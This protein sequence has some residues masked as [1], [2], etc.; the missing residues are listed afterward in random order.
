MVSTII[1]NLIS[2]AIKFTPENGSITVASKPY[3]G[4]NILVT[5]SDTGNWAIKRRNRAINEF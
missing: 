3:K 4:N 2:N 5:V 1:R